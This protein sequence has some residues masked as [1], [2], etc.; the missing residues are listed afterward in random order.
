MKT[1]FIHFSTLQSSA[2]DL[3]VFRLLQSQL[4]DIQ[5]RALNDNMATGSNKLTEIFNMIGIAVLDKYR[6]FVG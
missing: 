3:T 2:V 4:N 5:L 1:K 6:T